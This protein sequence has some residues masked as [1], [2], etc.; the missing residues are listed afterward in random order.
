M[1]TF[2]LVTR[3]FFKVDSSAD[4][5][6][7]VRDDIVYGTMNAIDAT[8]K[9]VEFQKK[10]QNTSSEKLGTYSFNIMPIPVE[11]ECEVK[12]CED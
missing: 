5:G 3:H 9:M 7:I 11:K 6:A 10:Y 4:S 1:G 12:L 8:R 2:Y